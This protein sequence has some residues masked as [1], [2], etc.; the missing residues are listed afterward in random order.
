METPVVS[1]KSQQL[2]NGKLR[3]AVGVP[4]AAL[5]LLMLFYA[6]W[7]LA[8]LLVFGLAIAL[9]ELAHLATGGNLPSWVPR[10]MLTPLKLPAELKPAPLQ[11]VSAQGLV[12]IA[13]IYGLIATNFTF[14]AWAGVVLLNI[15]GTDACAYWV[16]TT[17]ARLYEWA[18]RDIP[19]PL[20]KKPR[21]FAPVVSPK[22]TWAGTIGGVLLGGMAAPALIVWVVAF[23]MKQFT[24][25]GVVLTPWA[26]LLLFMS[27]VAAVC[28]DLLESQVKRKAEVKDAGGLI[29]GH[30]G[31]MERLDSICASFAVVWPMTRLLMACSLMVAPLQWL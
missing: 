14:A 29:P 31:A 18:Q 10:S 8:A 7:A 9:V 3:V 4:L 1:P 24:G 12:L 20:R 13:G 21:Q 25:H 28:G 6:P 2:S 5:V 11:W 23:A 27:S 30:G 26:Y 17:T 22:K 15:M 16:G 19:E